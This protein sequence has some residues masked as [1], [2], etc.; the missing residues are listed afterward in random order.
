MLEKLLDDLEARVASIEER[1]EEDNDFSI[2]EEFQNS[3]DKLM[4]LYTEI[5]S[6][7]IEPFYYGGFSEKQEKL[8]EIQKKRFK[9]LESRINI[10]KNDTDIDNDSDSEWMSDEDGNAED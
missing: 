1:L 9:K 8:F 7:D 10:I 3:F 2:G 4:D 5:K 6:N